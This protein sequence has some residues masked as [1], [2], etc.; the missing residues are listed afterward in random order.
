ME[1]KILALIFSLL[2]FLP[3]C[4]SVQIEMK[5]S[6]D[7]GE[8]LVAKVSGNFVQPPSDEGISFYRRHMSTA[9]DASLVKIDTDYYIYSKVPFEK[10]PDNYSIVIED[11]SYFEGATIKEDNLFYNFLITD[12]I[13]DFSINPAALIAYSD[14]SISVQNNKDTSISLDVSFSNKTE[15]SGGFFS[16]F[17][18]GSSN[19]DFSV[20]LSPGEEKSI[21]F[22]LNDFN[23]GLNTIKIKSA[24]LEYLIPIK[25]IK[26]KEIP[27]FDF[28]EYTLNL[29]LGINSSESRKIS[30]FNHGEESVQNISLSLSSSIKPYVNISTN[31]IEEIEPNSSAEITLTFF[32]RENIS[33]EGYLEAEKESIISSLLIYV[34]FED[35]YT[36]DRDDDGYTS[37]VDCNDGNYLIHPGAKEYC[38]EIDNDCDNKTDENC[39]DYADEDDDGYP[40]DVDCD[41][42][43]SSIHPGAKEY[44]DEIDNDCDDEEDENCKNYADKDKDGYSSNLDC[45]DDNSSIHPGAKEY[46]DKIDNNCNNRIDEN[47]IN[48]SKGEVSKTCSELGGFICESEL[49]CSVDYTQAKDDRCCVGGSC[50]KKEASSIKAIIGWTLLILVILFFSWFLISKYSRTKNKIDFSKKFKQI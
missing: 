3:F 25:I 22:E 37:D 5:D 48:A 27:N 50:I 14:F 43:N 24:N 21:S 49:V 38:D 18:G 46:C 7:L 39:K 2:I 35:N 11:V 19:N 23:E 8:T 9:M 13:A 26:E 10:I 36:R 4:S 44:C 34:G 40:S 17:T 28:E 45:N 12:K 30:I 32:S 15:S 6:Y 41:D 20:S 16:F 31:L 33:L 1:N 29:S 47:C 42:D